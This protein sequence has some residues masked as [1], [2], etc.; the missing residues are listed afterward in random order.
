MIMTSVSMKRLEK[1]Q[2]IIT[3]GA[4]QGTNPDPKRQRGAQPSANVPVIVIDVDSEP[5][6][7]SS[8]ESGRELEVVQVSG[9]LHTKCQ[10]YVLQ[11][12][13][14]KTSYSAY[15]FALHDS[16]SL[17]WDFSIKNGVMTLF[18]RN[19][20]GSKGGPSASCQPCLYLPKNKS[21]EGIVNR[22]QNGVHPNSPYSYHGAG[23][24]HEVLHQQVDKI[25][26][27]Q[28][29]GLNH[30]RALL[31][32]ATALSDYKRLVKAIASGNVAR[33]SRVIHI[34]LEQKKGVNG[35]ISTLRDAAEGFYRPRSYSEEEDMWGLLTWRLAG[36][37]VAHIN[38][39]SGH[40]P[41]L[42]YLRSRTIVSPI[43]PSPGMP[44]AAEVQKNTVA[45]LASVLD[46]IKL[47]VRHVV[48][49]FDE[50]ATEK[51]LRWDPKTNYFL[52]FCREHAHKTSME[53]INE[54][55]L[56][57]AFRALDTGE[58]HY[59]PEVRK[60]LPF[61]FRFKTS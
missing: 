35:I 52:G 4:Q 10:G 59:A 1:P 57:E 20:H 42:T 23:G 5:M 51:R 17:P 7:T 16:R 33:V 38:H 15:P 8:S 36:N 27:L 40:G 48:L 49:M 43:I 54:G 46:L 37:R 11:F 26:F 34:A 21:L 14:G 32:K 19:C 22:L 56:E 58:V 50:I 29:R 41:S 45:N 30:T 12:P 13:P 2:V 55:D 18:A 39:R 53:F 60:I 44:T 3:A 61:Y 6:G 47:R 9:H 31:G 28:L 24:L 25:A